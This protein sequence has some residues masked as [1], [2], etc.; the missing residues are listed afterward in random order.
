M[1]KYYCGQCAEGTDVVETRI[2]YKRVRR[3]RRC[4]NG[5][6]FSTV[7]VPHDAPKQLKKL[8][9]WFG[10]QGLDPDLVSYAK[11]QIDEIVLGKIEDEDGDSGGETISD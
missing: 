5:H 4:P 11:A 1:G 10:K 6:G 3:R 9:E 8:A 7:E 2:S